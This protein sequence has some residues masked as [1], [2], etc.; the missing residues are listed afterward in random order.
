[1]T[2][3]PGPLIETTGLTPALAC[4]R[5]WLVAAIIAARA[6]GMFTNLFNHRF[7]GRRTRADEGLQGR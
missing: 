7:T 1:M 4:A 6:R 3:L 5:S 2:F